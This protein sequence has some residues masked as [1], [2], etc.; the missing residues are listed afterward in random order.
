MKHV[1]E[2]KQVLRFASRNTHPDRASKDIK[3]QGIHTT[4]MAS[5]QHNTMAIT[6]SPNTFT[7]PYTKHIRT[8]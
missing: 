7:T 4:T 6:S 3:P 2:G 1:T 8:K 5:T